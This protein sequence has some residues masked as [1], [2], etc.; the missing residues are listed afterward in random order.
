MNVGNKEGFRILGLKIIRVPGLLGFFFCFQDLEHF[1]PLGLSR[2]WSKVESFL[3]LY[4][5]LPPSKCGIFMPT[6][7]AQM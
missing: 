6:L 4:S 3:H 7:W 5:P 1:E 2:Q